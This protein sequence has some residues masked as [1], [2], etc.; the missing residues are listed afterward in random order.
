VLAGTHQSFPWSCTAQFHVPL[1]FPCPVGVPPPICSSALCLTVA[2][3]Q[4][5]FIH[6]FLFP[7]TASQSTRVSGYFMPCPQCIC[8][9]FFIILWDCDLNLGLPTCKAGALPLAPYLQVHFC[10]AYFGDTVSRTICSECPQTAIHPHLILP[11]VSRRLHILPLQQYRFDTAPPPCA[12]R[13]SV[14]AAPLP[15]PCRPRATP[16]SG[17]HVWHLPALT[18]RAGSTEARGG[19]PREKFCG[20][21][22][23]HR[24]STGF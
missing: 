20:L 1:V 22:R 3:Q 12:S 19:P 10:S 14:S 11:P 7:G 21:A 15:A 24:S 18:S 2:N 4:H 16:R 17:S 23:P 5:F 8:F 9:T 6:S 13:P